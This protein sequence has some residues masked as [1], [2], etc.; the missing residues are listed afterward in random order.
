ML[1]VSACANMPPA[2]WLPAADFSALVKTYGP[3]VVN[4][5]VV[6]DG[7]SPTAAIDPATGRR[8]GRLPRRD[9]VDERSLGSGFIVGADGYILTNAHVVAQ[10]RDISVRLADRREFK[11]QLIGLDPVA[12]VA[13]LKIEASGLPVVAIGDPDRADVGDW[14]LAIGAP[15]GFSQS[16]TAGIISAKGRVLPGAEYMPFLQTDVPVNPGNSGGPLFNLRGEVIGI[17]SRIYSNNGGYQGLSFAI[18]IDVAMRIKQQLQ[19]GSSITRGRIGVAV[20]EVSQALAHSFRLPQPAGA[21]ISYVEPGGGADRAGLRP[22]DVILEV[23]G[24]AV[25]QSA[26]A[27]IFV[28]ELP[29]GQTATMAVW[30]DRE[31]VAMDVPIDR[32]E[33]PSRP[34][35]AASDPAT[36]L[37][38]VVRPL[39]PQELQVL[40][41]EAGLLVQRVNAAAARAGMKIGDVILAVNGQPVGSLAALAEA[42][43]EAEGSA[44]L[45]VQRRGT[46]IFVALE[47]PGAASRDAR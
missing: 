26:D 7:A 1:A 27:L 31:R 39:L 14:V 37:G 47:L 30:R 34:A 35:A 15:Y 9:Q 13:L 16:A 22:G 42:V 40:R 41:V 33:V 36:P 32:F 2:T 6:R 45:L 25:K 28:A 44:A 17:N 19:A 20:Q 11:A 3:A 21:L 4:I 46:R 23:R 10:G 24:R 8:Q 18:P 43:T 38:L 29:P 12:D 5:G